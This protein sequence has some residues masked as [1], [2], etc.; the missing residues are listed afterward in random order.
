MTHLDSGSHWTQSHLRVQ[1][2][3]SEK[4]KS[5]SFP[6]EGFRDHVAAD[7]SLLGV[8]RK[9]S[10]CGWFVVRLGHDEEMGPM[11]G[12]YGTLDVELEVQRTIKSAE[13]TAF[14]CLFRKA[15]G[16]SKLT[17]KESLMGRGEMKCS[18]SRAEDTDMWMLIR[19]ELHGV[20]QDCT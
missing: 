10:A 3:E 6:A 4:H 7:G 14:L 19:G 18:C 17:I 12:M 1:K 20:H 2:C 5:W 9:W 8:T 15:I 11:H 16:P 13:L